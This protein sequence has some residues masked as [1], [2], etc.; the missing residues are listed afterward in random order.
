MS[1]VL[2]YVSCEDLWALS[3]GTVCTLRSR[4]CDITAEFLSKAHG[5][6]GRRETPPITDIPLTLIEV[7]TRIVREPEPVLWETFLSK[8]RRLGRFQSKIVSKKHLN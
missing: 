2:L 5:P 7:R 1:S 4:D 3:L 8:K 6:K